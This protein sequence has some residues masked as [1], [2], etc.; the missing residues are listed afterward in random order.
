MSGR[1]KPG[2]ATEAEQLRE[3]LAEAHGMIRDL[4]IELRAARL[5]DEHL[6][7]M[8][9]GLIERAKAA[10]QVHYDQ[11]QRQLE[12]RFFSI[13]EAAGRSIPLRSTCPLCGTVAAGLVDMTQPE[14]TRTCPECGES[15]ILAITDKARSGRL[16]EVLT[17]LAAAF[18]ASPN[19]LEIEATFARLRQQNIGDH[20]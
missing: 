13:M 11:L 20:S 4:R 17:E 2:R 16:E 18:E 19:K 14:I 8:L 9:P 3:L 1:P 10:T 15:V 12:Q 7:E 6:A 5:V